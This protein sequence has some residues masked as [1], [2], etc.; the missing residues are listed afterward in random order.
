M[1]G[2]LRPNANAVGIAHFAFCSD[3]PRGQADVPGALPDVKR[4]R[5]LEAARAAV[6]SKV[7]R[8]HFFFPNFGVWLLDQHPTPTRHDDYR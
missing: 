4:R 2:N 6:T 1:V 7:E 8:E 3:G 5:F